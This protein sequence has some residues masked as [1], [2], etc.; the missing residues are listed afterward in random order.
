[1]QKDDPL[2]SPCPNLEA[3]KDALFN[4]FRRLTI[5]QNCSAMCTNKGGHKDAFSNKRCEAPCIWR[6]LQ[7]TCHRTLSK[8]RDEID[9]FFIVLWW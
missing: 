2:Y 5:G 8:A 6:G 1:M 7:A 9:L 4:K 3:I